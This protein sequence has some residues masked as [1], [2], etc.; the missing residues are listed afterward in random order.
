MQHTDNRTLIALKSGFTVDVVN[1]DTKKIYVRNVPLRMLWHFCGA[2][3]LDRFIPDRDG[4][5]DLLKIPVEEAEKAGVARVMR[6]MR[7]ACKAASVRPTGELRVPPSLAAG[8]ETIRACR[9]FG[10]HADADRIKDVMIDEWIGNEAWYMTDEHVELIWDGYHGSLRDTVFGDVIVWFILTEVQDKSHP[11]AEEIRWMLE[12][13]E[14]ET[15][16]ARVTDEVQ[17]KMWRLEDHDQFLGRCSWERAER[18]RKEEGRTDPRARGYL[19]QPLPMSDA[20]QTT[21]HH[22][23][24]AKALGIEMMQGGLWDGGGIGVLPDIPVQSPEQ[25][26]AGADTPVPHSLGRY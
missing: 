7:R 2:S 16:K 21:F 23:T 14:Y 17:R 15:L 18:M 4:R 12:Q 26:R 5:P 3:V 1:A 25:P 11:L 6:Y 10:L 24:S 20:E 22:G 9:V 19:Q 8:I 13:D